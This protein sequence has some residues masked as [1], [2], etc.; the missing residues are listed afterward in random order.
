LRRYNVVREWVETI[1]T[2]VDKL[3]PKGKPWRALELGCGNGRGL[4]S[5]TSQLNLSRVYH[6]TTPYTT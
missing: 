1:C 5:S 2:R 6:M 4:H 3:K